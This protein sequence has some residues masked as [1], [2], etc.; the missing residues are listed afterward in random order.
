MPLF[1]KAVIKTADSSCLC[2]PSPGRFFFPFGLR[3]VFFQFID[4]QQPEERKTSLAACCFTS[5]ASNAI[6]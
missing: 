5:S 6:A 2:T 1:L 3:S 4:V